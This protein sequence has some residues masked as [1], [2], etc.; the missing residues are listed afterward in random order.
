MRSW[1]WKKKKPKQRC[2][3]EPSQIKWRGRSQVQKDI[4]TRKHP[5]I[6][7]YKFARFRQKPTLLEKTIDALNNDMSIGVLEGDIERPW[8]LKNKKKG[9]PAVQL[10]TGGHAISIL[11]LYTKGSTHWSI[12]WMAEAG[13]PFYWKCSATCWCPSFFDLRT[14]EGLCLS[15]SLKAMNSRW[16]IQRRSDVTQC[17]WSLKPIFYHTL[18]L[19]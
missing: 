13:Y 3:S 6:Q 4:L 17:L 8:T 7:Y 1:T 15:P 5:A 11:S 14:F 18:I 10:T 9:I 2:E 16:S 12:N 19:I